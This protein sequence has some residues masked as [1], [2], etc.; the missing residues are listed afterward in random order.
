MKGAVVIP[1]MRF[2]GSALLGTNLTTN[3]PALNGKVR[4]YVNSNLCSF[5]KAI[6]LGICSGKLC[7]D[8]CLQSTQ[9]ADLADG[10]KPCAMRGR[11]F[12][13]LAAGHVPATLQRLGLQSAT[14]ISI[15]SSTSLSE[16]QKAAIIQD[17]EQVALILHMSL[18][19]NWLG[20]L[21]YLGF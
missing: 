1:G 12:P 3:R 2:A 19:L 18:T 15:N 4:A 16:S 7:P 17:F 11:R 13:E 5:L 6:V 10:G 20:Q 14:D 21:H 9:D 8:H